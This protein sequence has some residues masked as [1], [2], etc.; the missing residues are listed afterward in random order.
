MSKTTR[1]DLAERVQTE[2][3]AYLKAGQ[4]INEREIAKALDTT[5]LKIQEFDRL[6]RIRF[7]L[8]NPVQKYLG[9]LHERLRRIRTESAVQRQETRGEIHGSIDW[10][11]TIR[12]RY[13]ENPSDRSRFVTRT[14]QTEYQLPENLLVKKLLGIIAETARSELQEIDYEWRR[15]HWDD[16]SIREFLRQYDRNVHLDRIEADAETQISTQALDQARQSRQ[17]LYYEA[18]DL[19]RLLEQLLERKFESETASKLLFDTLIL[20]KTATLFELTV[21]FALLD[22]FQEQL[23]V[24]L[25]SIER[26]SDAIATM[27]DEN[28]EYRVYHD[29]TGRLRFR[30]KVPKE[31]N[32][33][34][35]Q[36]SENVV[37]RHRDV[38]SQE[39][40][41]ALYSGRPDIV[42]EK[43]PRGKPKAPPEQ[44]LL[45]EVKH[46]SQE[47]TL[48][49]GVYELMRYL[50]F[51]RAD[52]DAPVVWPEATFSGEK[53]KMYFGE[54]SEIPIS[55]V[56]VTDGVDFQPDTE[57][58]PIIHLNLSEISSLDVSTLFA[59]T[60]WRSDTTDTQSA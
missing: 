17:A 55:G 11:Q 33:P 58:L 26:G 13:A 6:L 28:W 59:A 38:M 2:L 37:S 30:E 25:Q 4:P 9:E 29:T 15:D 18:Y 56:V 39:S 48:S 60:G 19:Y 42:M 5:G 27:T 8:S 36:R 24:S 57:T 41:R 31:T 49:D 53:E 14:P 12:T 51:A 20:P 22:R 16:G 10:G 54:Q 3:I 44:I 1:N 23:S 21:V 45:G 50:E 34:Y 40:E 32:I 43:Y 7:A 35:L 46:T 47:S 52:S